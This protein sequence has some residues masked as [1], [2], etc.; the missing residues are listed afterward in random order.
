MS[1]TVNPMDLQPGEHLVDGQTIKVALN[2]QTVGLKLTAL[3]GGGAL[4][5]TLLSPGMNWVGVVVTSADSCLLPVALAG[6]G[7]KV[8]NSGANPTTVYPQQA[9]PNNA[10][11][12]ADTLNNLAGSGVS[13]IS[14]SANAIVDFWCYSPGIWK[15]TV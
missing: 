14:I 9:N 3:A 10:S 15:A 2:P 1:G 8:I 4:N 13:S 7:V 5:A 12:A 11:N 6:T